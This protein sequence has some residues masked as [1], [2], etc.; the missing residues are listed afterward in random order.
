MGEDIAPTSMLCINTWYTFLYRRGV[1]SGDR[2][3]MSMVSYVS[4]LLEIYVYMYIYVMYQHLVYFPL[5]ERFLYPVFSEKLKKEGTLLKC[6]LTDR[7]FE[8]QALTLCKREITLVGG[9]FYLTKPL[10]LYFNNNATSWSSVFL[11]AAITLFNA[12]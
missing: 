8:A 9:L 3:R 1:K 2:R 6:S 5:Q 10:Y 12:I 11:M 4:G 7:E